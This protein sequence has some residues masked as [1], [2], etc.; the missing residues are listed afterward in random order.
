MV[1]RIDVE[2]CPG[3]TSSQVLIDGVPAGS[4]RVVTAVQSEPARAAVWIDGV[5]QFDVEVYLNG[6]LEARVGPRSA[7]TERLYDDLGPPPTDR[8]TP[9]EPP[10]RSAPEAREQLAVERPAPPSHEVARSARRWTPA[11]LAGW[12]RGHSFARAPVHH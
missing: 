6:R 9:D 2:V 5:A 8:P 7:D 1:T 3:A 12:A 11:A 4:R 10:E